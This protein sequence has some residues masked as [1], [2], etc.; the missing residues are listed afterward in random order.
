MATQLQSRYLAVLAVGGRTFRFQTC[1]GGDDTTE[2]VSSRP[3][4]AKYP[5]KSGGEPDLSPITV[6]RD[7]D[8]T[9][10]DDMV[11]HLRKFIGIED[12]AT[13]QRQALDANRNPFGAKR[14]WTGVITAVNEPDSDT[15]TTS[16]KAQ[17]TVEIDPSGKA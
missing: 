16:D 7:Y 15:N 6:G 2:S 11:A 12:A 10:D 4:G 17:V 9:V 5:R 1:T 8:V 3:P 13:I 14:T